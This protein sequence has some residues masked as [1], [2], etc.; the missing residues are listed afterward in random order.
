MQVPVDRYAVVEHEAVT[1]PQTVPGGDPFQ[2]I[3]DA[4]LQVIDMLEA[5][6]EQVGGCLLTT[7]STRAEHRD[8]PV[9]GGI[10]VV[11]GPGRELPER[12]DFRVLGTPE[13][14]EMVLVVVTG[15][16]QAYIRTTDQFVPFLRRHVF[17]DLAHGID[18]GDAHAHD[19]PLQADLHAVKRGL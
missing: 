12:P 17:A 1:R 8:V 18:I 9:P 16:H 11:V 5:L 7:D 15:I 6:G 14:P 2:V 4:A 19:L 3:Q 10:E 13:S